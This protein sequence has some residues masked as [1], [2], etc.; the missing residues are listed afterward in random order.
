MIRPAT[1]TAVLGLAGLIAAVAGCGLGGHGD[2]L[3]IA[4]LPVAEEVE[5][6]R[7]V[8]PYVESDF[9]GRVDNPALQAYVRTVG[10]R[11]ARCTPLH[12]LPYSFSV[13]E[14]SAA[15]TVALP[16]GTVYVTRGLLDKLQTEGELAAA[17]ARPMVHINER[18]TGRQIVQ[19]FGLPG[20]REII[21]APDNAARRARL[22]RLG[23][24]IRDLPYSAEMQSDAD[25]LGLDYVAA[26]GY[27]PAAMVRLLEIIALPAEPK[28]SPAAA[29]AGSRVAV[30]RNMAAR[31]YMDRGGRVGRE[32]YQREVLDRLNANPP[33]PVSPL[34]GGS[35]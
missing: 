25:R 17:L 23:V 9:G 13:V 8:A 33:R 19:K 1:A 35:S 29:D 15:A 32:E 12:A 10:E 5:L 31:K 7:A 34:N 2:E 14:G 18:H 20:L 4:Y 30:I 16:G 28:A 3:R 22:A 21:S 24:A 27:N 26:A 6:G 11:V